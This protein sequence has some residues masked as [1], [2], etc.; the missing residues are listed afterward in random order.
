MSSANRNRCYTN[1]EIVIY[2]QPKEC[3]HSS[4]CYKELRSVFDPAKRPW[5][6]TQGA[7]TDKILQIVEK[8]PSKALS[9]R[10]CDQN[11]NQSEVSK[12]LFCGDETIF[13]K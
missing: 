4:I 13:D 6:N 3:I 7:P 2:W 11:R 12:K 5:V 9:F 1:G 10:W 8:C